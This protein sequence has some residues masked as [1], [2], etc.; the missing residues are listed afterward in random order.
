MK[1]LTFISVAITA[2]GLLLPPIAHFVLPYS[3]L[4]NIGNFLSG[5]GFI[6]IYVF[7]IAWQ[8]EISRSRLII[9]SV[10]LGLL[11]QSFIV[12]AFI[13]ANEAEKAMHAKHEIER[14]AQD[15]VLELREELHK[16]QKNIDEL[17][18]NL[19]ECQ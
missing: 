17:E 8:A 3:I 12:Y 11:F 6:M 19:K 18:A 5:I 16:A 1:K 15:Y 7:L 4:I 13:K 2:T 10:V 9:T 14:K